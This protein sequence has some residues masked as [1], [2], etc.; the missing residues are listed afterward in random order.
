[1]RL[2]RLP[3]Y[4]SPMVLRWPLIPRG[5]EIGASSR[6]PSRGVVIVGPTGAGKTTLARTIASSARPT[7]LWAA[8]SEST[9]RIPL[10]A[11]AHLIEIDA[12]VDPATAFAN[13][14]STLGGRGD[15]A[16][17]VDDADLLDPLSAA[18]VGRL[19]EDGDVHLVVTVGSVE[20][21]PDPAI[22][23]DGLLDRI[24][25]APFARDE[26][27][28]VLESALDGPL[29]RVSAQ[30]M[31]EISEGN[32]LYLRHLVEGSWESGLLFQIGG[33]WQLES[34]PVMTDELATLLVSRLPTADQEV[35]D[36]LW[37]LAFAGDLDVGVLARAASRDAVAEARRGGHLWI[38]SDAT[39]RVVRLRHP[40]VGEALRE[41][42]PVLAARSLRG[43]LVR[44]LA[45]GP[46]AGEELRMATLALD[47]DVDLDAALLV[48]ASERALALCD[49][50]LAERLA[51]AALLGG[52]G[53]RAAVVLARA[54]TWQGR[55][56]EADVL[57]GTFDPVAVPEYERLA[58]GLWRA[59]TYFFDNRQDAARRELDGLRE[60][61]TSRDG[62]EVL[63]S[64]D[65]TFDFF[66][67]NVPR[68]IELTR[69]LF[70]AENTSALAMSFAASTGGFALARAGHTD[71]VP[72][73]VERGVA[74]ATGTGFLLGRMQIGVAEVSAATLSGNLAGVLEM[75][76]RYSI[77]TPP[78]RSR[79]VV[80]GYIHGLAYLATGRVA[81]AEEHFRRGRAA[82][83]NGGPRMWVVLCSI[84]LCQ[85][86]GAQGRTE[87]AIEALDYAEESFGEH[88]A[89]F[90]PDLSHARAW[91]VAGCGEHRE[92]IRVARDAAVLAREGSMFGIEAMALHTAVR[93]GDRSATAR[94][95][96]LMRLVDG[97]FVRVASAHAHALRNRDGHG[98]DSVA[99]EFEAMSA[100]LLAADAAAQAAMEHNRCGDSLGERRSAATARR[101]AAECPGARTPALSVLENP[102]ALTGRERVVAALV[103]TGM[104][105]REIAERLTLSV[106]TVEGHVHRVLA[107]LGVDDRE[108]L[109]DRQYRRD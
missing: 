69:T 12:T 38:G 70:G 31:W 100:N 94:L 3:A 92:A 105:N 21:G 19:L 5:D 24:D 74:A 99:A 104:T 52:C 37:L 67:N 56:G 79:W 78:G 14:R 50:P 32:P 64:A 1:M 95:R 107:K 10:G 77:A 63:S 81:A 66:A 58:W 41:R 39:P 27:Y 96:R 84:G 91:I 80:D 42:T 18:L 83:V 9:R 87:Q 73:I 33:V 86:L 45:A 103:A 82:A 85:A 16:L 108:A 93:F 55:A 75:L 26:A 106:R 88:L 30:W 8:G 4:N 48:D 43:R 28:R 71:E 6:G 34:R 97:P 46:T 61:A 40:I 7:R 90:G 51:Q 44:A 13:A 54:M 72:D 65:V 15:T 2:D 11:F 49:Y 25:L 47:A 22:V 57:L 60:H 76:D 68:S 98:L 36:V 29:D 35:M 59:T 53:L 23:A 20:T 109:V 89:T 17:I 101:L 62:L 102:M